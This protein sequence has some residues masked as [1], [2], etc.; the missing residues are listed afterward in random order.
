[1]TA[2]TGGSCLA[3][4]H[5]YS[6]TDSC[7]YVSATKARQWRAGEECRSMDAYLTSIT[8]QDEMDFVKSIS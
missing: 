4:W 8:D 7:F 2:V 6:G 5:Y 1:M 3:G